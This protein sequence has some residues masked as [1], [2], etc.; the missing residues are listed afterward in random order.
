MYPVYSSMLLFR[1]WF[2]SPHLLDL[3]ALYTQ[4]H[5]R[6]G[7]NH[8]TTPHSQALKNAGS[9]EEKMPTY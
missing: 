5:Q 4:H 1:D 2:I 6:I 3:G 8:D 9:T 7:R